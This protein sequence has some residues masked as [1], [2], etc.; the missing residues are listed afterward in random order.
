MTEASTVTLKPRQLAALL[1]LFMCAFAAPLTVAFNIGTIISAFGAS[2]VEAGLVISAEGIAVSIAALVCSRL[3]SKYYLRTLLFAG[4]AFV[5]AG[6]VLTLVA[7]SIPAMIGCRI[8]AG[9]GIG[10]VIS[11]VMATAARTPKPEMTFGW[12]NGCAGAFISMMGLTVPYFIL[13]D[14]LDGAYGLYTTLSLLALLL[15]PMVP[16]IKAPPHEMPSATSRGKGASGRLQEHTGW[17]ALLG[18]G[19]FFFGQAGIAAFVERIGARI[20]VSLATLG[21]IFFFSGLLTIVGPI[22]AGMVGPRFGST[23]PLVLIGFLFCVAVLAVATGGDKLGFYLSVP[24]IMVLPAIL[25]PFFLGGLSVVDP[26]GKLAGAQPAFATM[27]G[28]LGPVAAGAVADASGFGAL[29]W[30]VVIMLA[31][32]MSLM[33]TATFKADSLR[34]AKLQGVI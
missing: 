16:N 23:K 15:V 3:I 28:A 20:D 12:V 19:I 7:E 18:L 2:R 13:R 8:V 31:V 26:T 33:A 14:G 34:N 11:A 6:N 24:M 29:G 17:I 1:V 22:A 32:G 4:L 25:L 5:A 9:L 21:A 27:G 10:T 30:F